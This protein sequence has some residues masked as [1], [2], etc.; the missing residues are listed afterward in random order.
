MA[1][2][3]PNVFDFTAYKTYLIAAIDAEREIRKGAQS[4]LAEHLGCQSAYLSMVQKDRADLSVEQAAAVNIFFHHNER[5]SHYFLLL[6][7]KE[8]AGTSVLKKYF[9]RQIEDVLSENSTLTKRLVYS[10]ILSEEHCA[11][12]YSAWYYTAIHLALTVPSLRR[13]E[14]ICQYLRLPQETVN[15]VLEFLLGSGL[16]TQD[17]GEY[18]V[19]PTRIHLGKDSPFINPSHSNWRLQAV[20]TLQRPIQDNFH[21]SSVVSASA[22]D[23]PKI[24]EIMIRAIES[25]RAVVKESPEEDLLC[26]NFD[27]FSLKQ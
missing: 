17:G 2:T 14:A 15:H 3:R 9:D 18:F 1:S 10:Q 7:Q 25:I 26:Y 22:K 20:Q 16:A 6:V 21:Y 19:G 13:R 4:R 12:F 5:E 23:M 8:R 24:R 27:L 11:I